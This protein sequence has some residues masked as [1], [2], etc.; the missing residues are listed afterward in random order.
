MRELEPWADLR[1]GG[2]GPQA[3]SRR[4]SVCDMEA[5]SPEHRE[6][7]P[8]TSSSPRNP[9]GLLAPPEG[10]KFGTSRDRGP[11]GL[12]R[13]DLGGGNSHFFYL[14]MFRGTA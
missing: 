5:K 6:P 9:G 3:W 11:W 7:A 14:C 10:W 4:V 12:R 8:L 1:P 2:P 13:R